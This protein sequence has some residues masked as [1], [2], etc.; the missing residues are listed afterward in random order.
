MFKIN[1]TPNEP[2]VENEYSSEDGD[3][4]IIT[5]KTLTSDR[6]AISI[7]RNDELLIE[8]KLVV[9]NELILGRHQENQKGN[10]AFLNEDGL[11]PTFENGFELWWFS[12]EDLAE[13][14]QT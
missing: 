2:N 1:L 14:V 11:Y 10:F 9:P 7:T 3:R 6:V 8:N 5:I 12:D 4:Y 13:F